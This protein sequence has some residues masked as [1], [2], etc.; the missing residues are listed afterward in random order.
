M[1]ENTA[2]PYEDSS[3]MNHNGSCTTCPAVT[4][5]YTGG[6]AL[7]FNGTQYVTVGIGTDF[8][9]M[10]S[11]SMCA[12]AKTPGLASG[13]TMNGVVAITY[14]LSMFLDGSGR[15]SSRMDNG[16]KLQTLAATQ[17][18][19]DDRFHHLCMSYADS[20]LFLYVDGKVA[21]NDTPTWLGTTR[22][23]TNG[24]NIGRENNSAIYKFNGVIDDVRIYAGALSESKIQQLYAEGAYSRS[25]AAR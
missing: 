2:S 11:F 3:G 13:Q 25:F 24:V 7:A 16:T 20:K 18:L 9:P 15:F 19:T 10:Q 5:G 22:W 1:F 17:V 14:G 6:S 12:W 21:A 23:P 4:S 8:F